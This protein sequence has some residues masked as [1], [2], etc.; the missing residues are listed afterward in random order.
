MNRKEE[1]E[2]FLFC[3]FAFFCVFKKVVH[4]VSI[5]CV[6][7]AGDDR[8]RSECIGKRHRIQHQ[9]NGAEN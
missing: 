2:S 9:T 5:R 6:S 1:E 4:G 7:I 3:L 8:I